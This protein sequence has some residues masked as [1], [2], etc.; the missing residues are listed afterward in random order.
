MIGARFHLNGWGLKGVEMGFEGGREES[1]VAGGEDGWGYLYVCIIHIWKW[2]EVR[3]VCIL[4]G[5][6]GIYWGGVLVYV[7]VPLPSSSVV[8]IYIF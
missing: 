7:F 4:W 1:M 8:F 2:G 6:L 3:K 5:N